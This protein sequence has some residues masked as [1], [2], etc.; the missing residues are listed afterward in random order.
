MLIIAFTIKAEL[1]ESIDLI[2][3]VLDIIEEHDLLE[4]I[5]QKYF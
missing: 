5:K 4:Y 3:I 2:D 1:K